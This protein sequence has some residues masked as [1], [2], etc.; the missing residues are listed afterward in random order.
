MTNNINLE[1]EILTERIL[2][3]TTHDKPHPRI[4]SAA[5]ILGRNDRCMRR[6]AACRIT[7]WEEKLS[8]YEYLDQ[9]IASANSG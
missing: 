5:L 8:S 9:S 2:R 7:V 3:V 1:P 6:K 4:A